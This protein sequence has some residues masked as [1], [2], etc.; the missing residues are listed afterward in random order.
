MNFGTKWQSK[1][2]TWKLRDEDDNLSIELVGCKRTKEIPV[3]NEE[4]VMEV[5]VASLSGPKCIN[6]TICMKL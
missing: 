4:D 6:E 5:G 3:D 2:H 1:K